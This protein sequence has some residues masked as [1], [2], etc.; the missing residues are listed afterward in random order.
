VENGGKDGQATAGVDFGNS[1]WPDRIT[2]SAALVAA[3]VSLVTAVLGVPVW[4]GLSLAAVSVAAAVAH[5]RS[6]YANDP[7]V[8]RLR[9]L[10]RQAA[11]AARDVAD[12]G[13]AVCKRDEELNRLLDNLNGREAAWRA[14]LTEARTREGRAVALAAQ[15]LATETAR[16]H[17]ERG[18]ARR[19]RG[20]GLRRV[21]DR[22]ARTVADLDQQVSVL[23]AEESDERRKLL[24]QKQEEHTRALLRAV[25]VVNASIPGV[26][27]ELTARLVE[28]GFRTAADIT[29]GIY[30]VRGI[31]PSKGRA[32]MTWWRSVRDRA[33]ETRPTRLTAAEDQAIRARFE[34][35][36]VVLLAQREQVQS[37]LSAEEEAIGS[38]FTQTI[39]QL[40]RE[41]AARRREVETKRQEAQTRAQAM[42]E[43]ASYNLRELG[44]ERQSPPVV[45]ARQRCSEARRHQASVNWQRAQLGHQVTVGRARLTR[46]GYV[47]RVL[48]L[49]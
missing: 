20:D 8:Q 14:K 32:I 31:G 4:S 15:T 11:D 43:D 21:R 39:A 36:C 25:F 9:V 33:D 6:R 2:W 34:A 49:A 3:A 7:G 19:D 24:A 16:L 37:G 18:Q 27:D 1:P 22:A 28:R 45:Q 47:K 44:R 29:A 23:G 46:L 38:T 30:S 35:R 42:I 5:A 17:S 48:G 26:A 13:V 12:A 41:E 40:D 10:L